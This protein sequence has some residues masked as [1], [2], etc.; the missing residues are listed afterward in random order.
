VKSVL[1][2]IRDAVRLLRA[3]PAIAL[4]RRSSQRGVIE[5]DVRRW[6]ECLEAG[7]RDE[8]TDRQLAW[9]LAAY[10]EFRNLLIYR[11]GA[12]GRLLRPLYRPMETLHLHVGEIGPGLFLQHGFATIVVAERIGTD[13][14]INQ[15]VTVGHIYDRGAPTI[16]DRV[17]LAAGAV[18]LGPVTVGDDSTIG[19][20]ATVVKDVPPGSVAVSGPTR[21]LP[22]GSTRGDARK[23]RP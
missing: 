8:S 15:Q 22:P 23:L 10:P 16:G 9:L 21:I 18:V 17:T 1:R 3:L 7:H 20:N 13:C 12:I 11:L 14:W 19:A 5:H 2:G 6:V 4:V